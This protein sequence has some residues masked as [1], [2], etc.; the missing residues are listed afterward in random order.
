MARLFSIRMR[1][2][3]QRHGRK[4]KPSASQ[5]SS[6]TARR[7]ARRLHAVLHI[8]TA[9]RTYMAKRKHS[10]HTSTATESPDAQR[11]SPMNE[12]TVMKGKPSMSM[13]KAQRCKVKEVIAPQ[14]SSP[15][16]DRPALVVRP[17][18]AL[19]VIHWIFRNLNQTHATD[20]KV[21]RAPVARTV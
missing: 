6:K 19:R 12:V 20:P 17:V 4:Q 2:G 18:N 8:Q 16:W 5:S 13:L 14:V 1:S 10:A 11:E 21:V 7:L 9:F 3:R 15:K